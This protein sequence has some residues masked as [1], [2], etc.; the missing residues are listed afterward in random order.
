[1]IS[2]HVLIKIAPWAL[3][4][5]LGVLWPAIV[6]GLDVPTYLFPSL[7]D[8]FRWLVAH[9]RQGVSQRERRLLVRAGGAADRPACEN[10]PVAA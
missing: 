1:M 8:V 7:R 9:W 3:L 2:R 10:V 6:V 5:L 4:V